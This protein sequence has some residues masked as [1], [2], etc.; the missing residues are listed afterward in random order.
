MGERAIDEIQGVPKQ[1]RPP[2]RVAVGSVARGLAGSTGSSFA[3]RIGGNIPGSPNPRLTPIPGSAKSRRMARGRAEQPPVEPDR[4]PGLETAEPADSGIKANQNV[5]SCRAP[6]LTSVMECRQ[7]VA[8]CIRLARYAATVDERDVLYGMA[9][10]WETLAGQAA[11]YE[12]LKSE[13]ARA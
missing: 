1:Q 2:Y 4:G 12:R 9:R 5:F 3:S 8:E 6:I 11:R 10:T 7:R 13:A